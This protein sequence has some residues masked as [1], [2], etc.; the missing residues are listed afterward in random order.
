MKTFIVLIPV[1][2][3]RDARKQCENIENSKFIID[4]YPCETVRANHVRDEVI[5]LIDDDTYDLSG[6]EVEPIT[7][8]MER[9]NNDELVFDSYFISYVLA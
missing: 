6:I 3:N 8:F 7:D 2:G 5:K 9:V 1:N 4:A